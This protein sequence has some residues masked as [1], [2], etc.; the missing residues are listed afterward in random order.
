MWV[1]LGQLVTEEP[2]LEH[3][4]DSVENQIRA[5]IPFSEQGWASSYWESNTYSS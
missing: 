1:T 3:P 4:A 5:G 2:K